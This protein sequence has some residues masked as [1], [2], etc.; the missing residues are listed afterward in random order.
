MLVE[1]LPA[2]LLATAVHV[3][4][5]STCPRPEQVTARLGELLAR[6]GTPP[7]SRLPIARG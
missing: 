5:N 6:P 7:Q 1:V 3:E 2:L 4:G